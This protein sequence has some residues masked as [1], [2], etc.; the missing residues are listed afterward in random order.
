MIV[1]MGYSTSEKKHLANL[2]R[3]KGNFAEAIPLYANLWHER[4]DPF[5]GAGLL[6]CYRK[7]KLFDRHYP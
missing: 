7:S 5:D 4:A 1:F 2:Y 3:K 6:C